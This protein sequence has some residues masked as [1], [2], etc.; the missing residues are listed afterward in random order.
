MTD[1]QLKA[2]LMYQENVDWI[3]KA[4]SEGYTIVDIGIDPSRTTRSVFYTMERGFIY[5]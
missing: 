3:K 5:K 2:T 1:A 4:I